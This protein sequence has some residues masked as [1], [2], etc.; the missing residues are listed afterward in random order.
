MHL[1]RVVSRAT[2][3][4]GIGVIAAAVAVGVADLPL[5]DVGLA[6]AGSVTIA[7]LV[8]VRRR[9]AERVTSRQ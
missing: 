6:A 8:V 4:A 9:S 7:T 3:W 5:V 2:T 1:P